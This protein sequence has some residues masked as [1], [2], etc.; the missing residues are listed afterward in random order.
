M[1][2]EGMSKEALALLS[3]IDSP[4]IGSQNPSA[5]IEL[6]DDVGTIVGYAWRMAPANERAGLRHTIFAPGFDAQSTENPAVAGT[7]R[8]Y[9]ELAQQLSVESET[10]GSNFPME[11]IQNRGSVV[12]LID[13]LDRRGAIQENSKAIQ[14][15]LQSE[16]FRRELDGKLAILYGYSMG[17]LVSRH[18]LLSLE[19]NGI[20]HN[21]GAYVSLD[22]PHRGAFIPPSLEAYLRTLNSMMQDTFSKN[23]V[24]QFIRSDVKRAV[25]AFNSIAVR[26]LLGI[27]IGKSTP[28][29]KSWP[30][31][32][33]TNRW[34][35]LE[36]YYQSLI[37]DNDLARHPAFYDLREDMVDMGGYPALP[38]NI[39]VSFGRADGAM[40]MPANLRS[41]APVNFR[42]DLL[43]NIKVLKAEL[44][45]IRGQKLCRVE[46]TDL[47]R[48]RS[49]PNLG[50]Y[51]QH[52][53][54]VFVGAGS[55]INSFGRILEVAQVN[56]GYLS[57]QSKPELGLAGLYSKPATWSFLD[58]VQV[59]GYIDS[60][61]ER[62]TF[63]PMVSAFDDKGWARDY[64]NKASIGLLQTPFDV[65]IADRSLGDSDPGSHTVI[66]TDV[67]D[68]ILVNI[69]SSDA[70]NQQKSRVANERRGSTASPTSGYWNA[71]G[72]FDTIRYI[73]PSTARELPVVSDK[74]SERSVRRDDK[75][76]IAATVSAL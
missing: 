9:L 70:Y 57:N 35:Q 63:V 30:S 1:A 74:E 39:G 18:A 17:G 47:Q 61:E 3:Y 62:L 8:S 37:A 10:S 14:S 11:L 33:K 55:T 36:K 16:T 43:G 49:C 23:T 20:Q 44:K 28:Q 48:G 69:Y 42:V 58:G 7:V 22:A 6:R 13:Y 64:P 24:G 52:L 65:T 71:A 34:R 76:V 32:N 27:Y 19:D 38:L 26:Q 4:T 51:G 67:I 25:A 40:L 66:T 46:T 31:G 59:S 21:V 50:L 56:T 54:S 29:Y 5:R 53:E 45:S 41:S 72:V 68:Q 15:L 75:S 60:G 73:I 12:W 2:F